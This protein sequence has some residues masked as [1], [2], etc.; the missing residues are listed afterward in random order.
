MNIPHTSLNDKLIFQI[1]TRLSI[2]T[3]LVINRQFVLRP[4]LVTDNLHDSSELIDN[5]QERI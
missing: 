5:T 1:Y 3:A 4:G 2:S